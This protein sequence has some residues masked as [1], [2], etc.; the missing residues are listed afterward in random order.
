MK[1]GIMTL[2]DVNNYGGVLQAIAIQ[3][4]LQQAGHDAVLLHIRYNPQGNRI[5]KFLERPT[6]GIIEQ[7]KARKFATFRLQ[8]FHHGGLP[9]YDPQA[10]L[11]TPPAFDAYVCG[12]D[13]IWNSGNCADSV[14]RRLFFL[15]FGDSQAKRIA[16]AASWGAKTLAPH[17]QPEVAACLARFDA[18]SVREKSGVAI[19]SELGFQ[20]LWL[21]DPALLHQADYWHAIADEAEN[22]G[23]PETLFQCEYRWTPCVDFQ[24]V[25]T[26]LCRRH[27]WRT[28]IPFAN[29]PLRQFAFTRCLAPA[30]WLDGIRKSAFVLTNSYHA[31]LFSIQF[32]RPFLVIPLSG[33]YAG[34]N[35]RIF[36]VTKRL[37]LQDRVITEYNEEQII[38]RAE[39]PID[40]DAVDARLTDWRKEADAFLTDAL[41]DSAG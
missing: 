7:I 8:H 17:L 3:D 20:A 37:G 38:K 32:K 13:Q 26:L 16:Y 36:S 6:K 1:L 9:A 22:K 2:I 29:K 11:E 12:S 23:A 5:L 19:A 34:M 24:L 33:K 21:P 14:K 39:T 18:I 31:L 30:E 4:Y 41:N 40:W 28:V 15:D 25:R 27:G 10:F 35:E